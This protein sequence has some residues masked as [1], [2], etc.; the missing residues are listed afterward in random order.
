[1]TCSAVKGLELN[2]APPTN[3]KCI[4]TNYY[5]DN[6]TNPLNVLCKICDT[7]CLTCEFY[8]YNCYTCDYG[9]YHVDDDH[10]L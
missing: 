4:Q 8:S 9:Y 10:C 3:C 1:M 5:L 6:L 2:G 7:G